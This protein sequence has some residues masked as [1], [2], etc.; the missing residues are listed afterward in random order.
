LNGPREAG[1]DAPVARL[2]DGAPPKACQRG[3][4]LML[5]FDRYRT[6]G[7]IH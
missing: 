2:A 6:T 3:Y 5:V 1:K 4:L 7:S